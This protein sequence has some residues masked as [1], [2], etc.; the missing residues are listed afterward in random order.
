MSVEQDAEERLEALIGKLAKEGKVVPF[1]KRPVSPAK[2]MPAQSVSVIGNGNAAVI[3]SH[4]QVSINVRTTRKVVA[5]VK[6]GDVHISDRQAAI[7]QGMVAD[8]CKKSGKT[9]Q[10]V[11]GHLLRHMVVPQYR[12]IPAAAYHDATTY[13]E[14]WLARY[15]P[16]VES[17]DSW[18]ERKRHLGY[19]KVNQK[20]KGIPDALVADFVH[21]VLGKDGLSECSNRELQYVRA[22]VKTWTPQ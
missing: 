11:W 22:L 18:T 8:I 9:H 20:K 14:R 10:F 17:E 6:P 4:N 3:G 1:P 15:S 5:N 21:E 13:L 7:L 19:I 2:K 12:L 16:S